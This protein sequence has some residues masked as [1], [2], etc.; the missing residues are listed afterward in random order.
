MIP[1]NAAFVTAFSINNFSLVGSLMEYLIPDF[2]WTPDD[3][4]STI[5]FFFL[6]A[7]GDSPDEDMTKLTLAKSRVLTRNLVSKPSISL[8]SIRFRLRMCHVSLTGWPEPSS[9]LWK[10]R[11]LSVE[12]REFIYN[13]LSMKL[14]HKRSSLDQNRQKVENRIFLPHRIWLNCLQLSLV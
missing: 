12:N 8:S 14:N 3:G 13:F 7:V 6:T 1:V 5:D 10:S 9:S 11:I 2:L 4:F